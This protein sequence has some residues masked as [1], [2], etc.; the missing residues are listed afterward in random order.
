MGVPDKMMR[1]NAGSI[2]HVAVMSE[3][4]FF[5][6][7]PS[8]RHTAVHAMLQRDALYLRMPSYVMMTASPYRVEGLFIRLFNTRMIPVD[9]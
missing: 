7:C 1:W 5:I 6:F 4:G 9:G 8:S 2:L 3:W